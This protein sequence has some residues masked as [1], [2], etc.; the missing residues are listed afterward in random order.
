[1]VSTPA[2]TE[3]L[4]RTGIQ[5]W[6]EPVICCDTVWE[7]NYARFETAEE[8]IEK[9]IKRFQQLGAAN[10]PATAR[11]LDLFCG[12]GNGLKALARLGFCR[13]E[14]VDLSERLLAQYAGPAQLYV[15]DA[16]DLKLDDGCI[17]VV[18]V[19]G[20]LHHLPVLEKDLAKVLG[21][22]RRVLKPDGRFVLVEPWETPFLKAI[23]LMCRQRLL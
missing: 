14:G 2:T 3:P 9:F 20:G 15:G 22:I 7:E 5:H 11:I 1:M 13:L 8:E 12:R 16:T 23:H 17:D 19:Q 10:W 4:T 18:V 21:E 6:C